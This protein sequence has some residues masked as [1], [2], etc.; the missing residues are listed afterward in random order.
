[1]TAEEWHA[2]LECEPGEGLDPE[3][4]PD[5][6]DYLSPD[7]V[8]LT[9]AELAEIREAAALAAPVGADDP[10]PAGVA[11][12]LTAQAAAAAARRRGPGQPGSMRHLARESS[13]RAAAFG[14]GL[15]LDVMPACPDLALLADRAAGGDDSYRG[16]SDDELIGVLCAWDRLESHTAARKLA[17]IAE[18]SRRRPPVETPS[19][20]RPAGSAEEDFTAD[21]LA[22][23]LACPA[24]ARGA[25]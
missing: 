3:E 1:M 17:A 23:V 10:D 6:E 22:H 20:G 18:L 11:R 12:G 13:S 4:Y 14:T 21:E 7:A 24:A 5:E 25:C 15:P 19:S 2:W 8:D 16:V 9:G